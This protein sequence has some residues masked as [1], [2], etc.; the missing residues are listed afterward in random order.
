M[1]DDILN[2]ITL[3]FHE[4]Q[5]FFL[6][7]GILGDH[8]DP[9]FAPFSIN[10]NH[11]DDGELE[12]QVIG[13]ITGL[14]FL[15]T[16]WH[17][18]CTDDLDGISQDMSNLAEA[19]DAAKIYS[20]DLLILDVRPII[21]LERFEINERFRGKGIGAAVH[22][23]MCS[24]IDNKFTASPIVFTHPAPINY[25]PSLDLLFEKEVTRIRRFYKR[26]G[27]KSLKKPFKEYYVLDT[28]EQE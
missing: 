20:D 24:Y 23:A 26:L 8:S 3:D 17:E 1:D 12:E 6:D 4:N 15:N 25:G 18:G 14:Y 21:F 9:S 27:F 10:I 5:T 2:K 11:V 22:K 13:R 19:F 7:G 28:D 16:V